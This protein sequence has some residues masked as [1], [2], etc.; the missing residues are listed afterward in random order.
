VKR[1]FSAFLITA[2][3]AF[4]AACGTRTSNN[5]SSGSINGPTPTP[6]PSS[7]A[8]A[9]AFPFE[10]ILTSQYEDNTGTPGGTITTEAD[11]QMPVAAAAGT[12]NPCNVSIPEGRM[13]F[14]TLT[15]TVSVGTQT[16][17]PPCEIVVFQPYYYK[18]SNA[19]GFKPS[20]ETSAI[21]CSASPTPLGCF[22][23][24]ATTI[25]TGFPQFVGEYFLAPDTSSQSYSVKS[26]NANL[27]SSDRWTVNNLADETS[28]VAFLNGRDGYVANS[29]VDYSFSCFD[30]FM[31]PVYGFTHQITKIDVTGGALNNPANPLTN[32]YPDWD[33]NS[34]D[35]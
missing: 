32:Q 18:A 31:Q 19:A 29:M 25:V 16:L 11:C 9:S 13:H 12:I 28:A 7:T 15:W 27:R 23:G 35:R 8:G 2:A 21:D 14:S 33:I 26:A 3:L 1:F 24:P 34:W 30:K 4:T 22:S 5:S 6:T 10:V 17:N 20:W